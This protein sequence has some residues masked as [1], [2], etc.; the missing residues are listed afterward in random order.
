MS[1]K[2]KALTA[3]KRKKF[4]T[5]G[6]AQTTKRGQGPGTPGTPGYTGPVVNPLDDIEIDDPAKNSLAIQPEPFEVTAATAQKL[7]TGFDAQK[8]NADLDRNSYFKTGEFSYD[9]DPA[10]KLY[11]LKDK[12]GK[13]I[14]KNTY[15]KMAGFTNLNLENY[16][17]Q[18]S[19]LQTQS[20]DVSKLATGTDAVTTNAAI[21]A[22]A[23]TGTATTS[24]AATSFMGDKVVDHDAIIQDAMDRQPLFGTPP[25][26]MMDYSYDKESGEYVID[27]AGW[28]FTGDV[29]FERLS[30]EEFYDK[31]G[32]NSNRF[33][34]TTAPKA[35]TASTYE[36]DQIVKSATATG[37][38]SEAILTKA[39]AGKASLTERAKAPDR[40]A[41]EEKEAMSIPAA[42]RPNRKEYAEGIISTEEYIVQNPDDPDVRK[43]FYLLYQKQKLQSLGKLLRVEKYL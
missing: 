15:E 39:E 30:P 36:A 4:N 10:S 6:T 11:T 38:K 34:T 5:G 9:Y 31:M 41:A 32:I 25:R 28:G 37:A 19:S 13:E 23:T 1:N 3:L 7:G 22:A 17:G 42:K 33:T 26:K 43:E 14:A 21:G 24:K 12:S 20:G 18:D 16:K 35:A 40:D 8:F 27:K 2:N 29:R